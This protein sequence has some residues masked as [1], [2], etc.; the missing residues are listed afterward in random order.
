MIWKEDAP[1][2]DATELDLGMDESGMLM[3]SDDLWSAMLWFERRGRFRG[4][5]SK[6]FVDRSSPSSSSS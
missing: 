6:S 1:A 2:D 5:W 3:G 4:L